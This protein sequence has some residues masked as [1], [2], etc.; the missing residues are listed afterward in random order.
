MAVHWRLNDSWR[1]RAVAGLL[2]RT[3]QFRNETF[4][5]LDIAGDAV[6]LAR[7]AAEAEALPQVFEAA[8]VLEKVALLVPAWRWH[9][10]LPGCGAGGG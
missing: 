3:T 5:N 6:A 2:N 1:R 10:W 9:P 8:L 4:F 7:G